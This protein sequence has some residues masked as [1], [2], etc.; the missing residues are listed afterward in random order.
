MSAGPRGCDSPNLPFSEPGNKCRC[1][2]YLLNCF[3]DN[4]QKNDFVRGVDLEPI[5]TIEWIVTQHAPFSKI[6]TTNATVRAG[7]QDVQ[8][9][10]DRYYRTGDPPDVN[11]D[12]PEGPRARPIEYGGGILTTLKFTSFAEAVRLTVAAEWEDFLCA[13]LKSNGVTAKEMVAL[14]GAEPWIQY[15]P[16]AELTKMNGCSD[17]HARLENVLIAFKAF[18]SPFFGL[19]SDRKRLA[20]GQVGFYVRDGRDH[21]GDG[22][23]TP[24]WIG[25]MIG[26]MPEFSSCIARKVSELIYGADE[27]PTVVSERLRRSFMRTQDFATLVEDAVVARYADDSRSPE[28]P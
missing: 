15:V 12:V 24:Q 25:E 20:A 27:V 23:A 19:H 2:A 7:L 4:R 3:R 5:R 22:P 9:A 1:G 16:S 18:G 6:L 8:F 21:R 26:K 28:V 13:P 11:V 14:G 10:R 17:C